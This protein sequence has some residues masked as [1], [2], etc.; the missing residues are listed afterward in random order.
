MA[1]YQKMTSED[2]LR[3]IEEGLLD[4]DYVIMGFVKRLTDDDIA[5][6]CQKNDI[7]YHD[8]FPE[9]DEE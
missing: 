8:L 6:M 4:K 3:A 2:L 1:A 7:F 5:D 9:E